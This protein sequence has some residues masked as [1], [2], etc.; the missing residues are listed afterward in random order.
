MS[1][2]QK[3]PC[4]PRG[5]ERHRRKWVFRS[6]R[7]WARRLQASRVAAWPLFEA[8]TGIG[9]ASLLAHIKQAEARQTVVHQQLLL[10]KL[11]LDL[12]QLHYS[13]PAPIGCKLAGR[14][15]FQPHQ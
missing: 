9:G 10:N 3:Q 4:L 8:R 6:V 13:H 5:P 11:V 14:M 15:L 7:A 2:V 12:A 1:A